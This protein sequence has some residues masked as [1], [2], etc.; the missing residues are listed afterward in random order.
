[1]GEIRHR[2]VE[3]N[4]INMHIA[5][6]GEGPLVILCHG[7]PE[8]WY[9]W[10]HQLPA[11]AARGYHAV[12]PDQRGYGRTDAPTDITSYTQFQLV[13]DIV[14]LVHALGED[15]AVIVGHDWGAPVA[16]NAA[17][18][19]PD[20]FRA[21]V[22]MSVPAT[23]RPPG[24]P[25]AFMK[26][27]FG[28]T[29]F[30]MLYFQTPGVAEHELQ[31]DVRRT[32][33]M[34][35]YSASGAGIENAFGRLPKT[36]G[37]L[38]QM[39]EPEALPDWLTEEDLDYFTDE[40][41]RAG[42]RGGLNWYRNIDRNWELSAPFAGRHIEQRA[43]FITGDRDLTLAMPGYEERMRAVVPNL[44]EVV[45]FTGVGH[46]TQQENPEGTNEAI[47]DFL[48]SLDGQESATT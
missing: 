46:W 3:T 45:S 31:K 36:A 42:F 6:A 30:Y 47:L 27:R 1:M 19:R 9:S 41:L 37:F 8:S 29:F 21:V 48:D 44:G 11:L 22:G 20:I 24:A 7:F 38:D 5:E 28:D 18:W 25:T 15:Q 4:G 23:A 2:D 26:Q 14:G 34:L 35:L 13:G 16:W 17:M 10:R 40:F 39:T 43:L 32:L 12:A 33:R